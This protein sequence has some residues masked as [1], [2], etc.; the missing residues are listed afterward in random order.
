LLKET[1]IKMMEIT[2]AG[3]L[4]RALLGVPITEAGIA[5]EQARLRG[6]E[7]EIRRE[8]LGF[9]REEAEL[10]R[11]GEAQGEAGEEMDELMDMMLRATATHKPTYGMYGE[12]EKVMAANTLLDLIR[13]NQS[14]SPETKMKWLETAPS[15]LGVTL[16]ETLAGEKGKPYFD[17]FRDMWNQSLSET[18]EVGGVPRPAE[19]YK[20][21]TF[22]EI[23]KEVNRIY[24][25]T[26]SMKKAN[27]YLK[28]YGLTRET[29]SEL[30][31][32]G[33]E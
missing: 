28:K 15:L 33:T 17:W 6:E 30:L 22:A 1:S 8:E 18:A 23:Q 16:P 19:T 27:Q 29:Y 24:A 32:K 21:L 5:G 20:G 26:G 2:E 31:A 12:E 9:R 25:K 4:G 10:K 3:E 14:I 13:L 11:E 7:V